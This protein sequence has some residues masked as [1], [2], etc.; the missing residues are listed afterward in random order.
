MEEEVCML[1]YSREML[2]R[3]KRLLN[4][5]ARERTDNMYGTVFLL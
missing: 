5:V 1:E 2:G 4:D 3:F